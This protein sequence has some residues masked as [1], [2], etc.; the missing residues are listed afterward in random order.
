MDHLEQVDEKFRLDYVR[1]YSRFNSIIISGKT[2]LAKTAAN[3]SSVSFF[4]MS[5]S[6]IVSK[7]RGDSEK[8]IKV[9]RNFQHLLEYQKNYRSKNINFSQ[10]VFEMALLQAPSII[11]IDEIDSFACKRTMY[12]HEASRRMKSEMFTAFDI[13]LGTKNNVFILATTNTP[14]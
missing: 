3:E 8:L 14:W 5:P 6:L 11:F 7:W 2:L 4:N 12:E 9:N 1:H 13:V 10:V